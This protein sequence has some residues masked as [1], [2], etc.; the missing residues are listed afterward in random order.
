MP[1]IRLYSVL[2]LALAAQ[3]AVARTNY[4]GCTSFTSTVTVHTEIGYGNTYETVI[5]Y[6][7]DSLE[8]C[9]G[10]DCGGGR[11][12]PRTV[13][14]CPAYTGTETVTARFLTADPQAP[15]TQI[16]VAPSTSTT[17]E[18][19]VTEPATSS[20]QSGS[21]TGS[22]SASGS[23]PSS[24][25]PPTQPQESG[26]GP[27]ETTT[28]SSPASSPSST[29]DSAAATKPANLALGVVAAALAFL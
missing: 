28:G 23:S 8:I 15:H 1:G 26:T 9:Q 6:V 16:T 20:S 12:P 10:V 2:A 3:G 21:P 25:T 11:A 17:L 14:G 22:A 29:A 19:T 7:S 13:P 5:W 4:D 27:A 24:P 18:V